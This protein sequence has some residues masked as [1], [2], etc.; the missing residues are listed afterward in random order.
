VS[1]LTSSAS[2]CC[3]VNGPTQFCS[4]GTWT[5]FICLY[6][7]SAAEMREIV[8]SGSRGGMGAMLN[9]AVTVLSSKS[10]RNFRFA[11]FVTHSNHVSGS[12]DTVKSNK[13]R[14]SA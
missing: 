9:R 13:T 14:D 3:R 6:R 1:S 2:L 8:P 4:L 12:D 11:T 7:L 5:S 10:L